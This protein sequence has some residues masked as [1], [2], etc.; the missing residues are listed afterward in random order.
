VLLE[1]IAQVTV[2]INTGYI[3]DAL[4]SPKK[5]D[6]RYHKLLSGRDISRY[7]FKWPGAW[8]LYDKKVV[9]GY[10]DRGRTL[11]EKSIFE[12]EKI[13]VQRTR[14][15]MLRKIVCALDA[16]RYYNLNRLSNIVIQNSQYSIKYCIGILNSKLMDFYFQ[17]VFNEYE[18]KPAHLRRLPIHRVPNPHV[19]Q[20]INSVDLILILNQR[21]LVLGDKYTLERETL[22]KEIKETDQ[23]IDELVYDLYG[24]TPEERKT[25]GES[26]N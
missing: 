24:L 19:S 2:G 25:V 7:S 16:E 15:G 10:G 1:S 14:R 13:L 22:E 23:K 21:L 17:K 20:I 5:I 8:I 6:E 12:N 18:V 9:D 4:V 26:F 3:K 11:P